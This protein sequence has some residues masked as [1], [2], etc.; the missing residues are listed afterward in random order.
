MECKKSRANAG[1]VSIGDEG[2]DEDLGVRHLY[3]LRGMGGEQ[4]NR[5]D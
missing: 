4:H 3:A 5:A 1:R 2:V